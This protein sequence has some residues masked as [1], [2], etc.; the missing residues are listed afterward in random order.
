MRCSLC[1]R[2]EVAG[3]LLFVGGWGGAA[4]AGVAVC[5][6]GCGQA[7]QPPPPHR[8]MPQCGDLQ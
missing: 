2:G 3:F 7:L 5:G 1:G 6:L 4:L 8:C